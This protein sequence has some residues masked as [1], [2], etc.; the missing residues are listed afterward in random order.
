MILFAR[1]KDEQINDCAKQYNKMQKQREQ[2]KDWMKSFQI[3]GKL[4]K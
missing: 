2:C 4:K 3:G 1:E